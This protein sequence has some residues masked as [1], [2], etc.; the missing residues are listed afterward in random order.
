MGFNMLWALGGAAEQYVEDKTAAQE[1]QRR[2]MEDVLKATQEKGMEAAATHSKNKAELRKLG[3]QLEQLGMD[4][5]RALVVLDQGPAEAADIIKRLRVASGVAASSGKRFMANDYVELADPE[6]TGLSMKDGINNITGILSK[7][8]E[9]YDT[10][11]MSAQQAA[12][13]KTFEDSYGVSYGDLRKW[14]SGDLEYGYTPSGTISGEL[15]LEEGYKQEKLKGETEIVKSTSIIKGVDAATAQAITDKKM[16]LLDQQI[17]AGEWDESTREQREADRIAKHNADIAAANQRYKGEN[18][19]QA[20]KV[21]ELQ[22]ASDK[23]IADLKYTIAKTAEAKNG[24]PA[25]AIKDSTVNTIYDA[26]LKTYIQGRP[27]AFEGAG[28]DPNKPMGQRFSFGANK[29]AQKK[30]LQEF[31][32]TIFSSLVKNYGFHPAIL[33]RYEASGFARP[34]RLEADIGD[35]TPIDKASYDGLIADGYADGT[36]ILFG[37]D[38]IRLKPVYDEELDQYGLVAY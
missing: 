19:D 31:H 14:A 1:A 25:S 8:S 5:D 15:Y 27:E 26:A 37:K 2:V 10:S 17:S 21:I 35:K 4:P 24:D 16:T 34:Y 6:R 18:L 30:E 22:N 23:A 7:D 12:M 3:K 11:G 29:E 32:N 20:L 13:I 38:N 9:P 33:T 28:Y 36:A